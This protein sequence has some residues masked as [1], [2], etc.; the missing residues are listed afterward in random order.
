[1]KTMS[2]K[3]A[4]AAHQVLRQWHTKDCNNSPWNELLI[5]AQRLN[6]QPF[7]NLALA[8]KEVLLESL[9]AL[10]KQAGS[11]LGVRIV[12]EHFLD[13]RTVTDI[14][15]RL[16]LTDNVVYNKQQIAIK[17]LGCVIWRAESKTRSV[18]A[19]RIAGRLIIQEPPPL[20]GV[21]DKLA[22]LVNILAVRA[23]PWL[24][25]VVGIGGIGKTSLADAA[26][27]AI[28]H[29]AIFADVA[30]VSARQGRF[31]LWDGLLE[32]LEGTPALTFEGLMD[33]IIKQFDFQDLSRLPL[34]QKRAGL[35]ARLKAQPYLV[36]VDNL[37]TAADYGALV[38]KLNDLINPSKFLL[39]G[40]HR[41]HQY[42]GVRSLSLDELS[43]QD[44]LALL[45][46]EASTRGMTDVADTPDETLLRVYQAAGGNPL[47]L[48]LLVGQMGVF[49][50][51]QVAEDLRQAQGK[52]V[53]ELYRFIYWQS[54]HLLT[55]EAQRV[56]S[57]M[58]LVAE[59]GGGL[60]HISTISELDGGRLAAAL[61]HLVTLSLVNVRGAVET[62]RYSIHRLTETFLLNEVLKWQAMS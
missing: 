26:V 7:P 23:L 25:A 45:R 53:K 28:A 11:S 36:V 10:D 31:T 8:V 49:S 52:P 41:L 12:R 34:T 43:A 40:R 46:H 19:A 21:K 44:S 35:R 2:E 32:A 3:L 48:K 17:G 14:A 54:W 1:M 13:R 20:F 47:A 29:T 18:K 42:P 61:Q 33:A 51:R 37:E 59:T 62:R 6:Q 50:P 27:R 30:W 38:P 16:N 5:V 4:E 39:T 22:E 24:A 55:E 58:P 15:I 60:E 9:Q 57:V 56:L